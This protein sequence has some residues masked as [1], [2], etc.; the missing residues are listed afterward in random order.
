MSDSIKHECGLALIRLRKPLDYYHEKYGTALY[1][2]NKLHVLLQ[3]QRNRG[4]DG[5]GIA[6]IKLDPLPGN[7]Y[8]SRKRSNSSQYLKDLFTEVYSRFD[9]VPKEKFDDPQWLKANRPYTGEILLGH[10]RYG[11]H[12]A[13]TIETV[14]PFLRQNNWI[15]RN[16]VMAGNFNMTNMKELFDELISFGQH[17]KERS[18]TVTIMEKIGHFL[19]LEVDKLFNWF[20]AE[21]Y[22]NEE[23]TR[24]I[25]ENI[26]VK[27][28]LQ[29]ATRKIDGGYVM[30]GIIGH[31]DAFVMRDP[32][33][34]R[35]AFYYA[36]DEIVAVASERPALM[37]TFGVHY[38][39]IKELP[40]GN[41]LII[42]KSG[43]Y[44]VELCKDQLERKACSFERIYFSRGNDK[45][46]Y[47][48]RKE[49]GKLL[50]D[51]VLAAANYDFKH[52]VFSFIPNTAETAYIG[53]AEELQNICNR[54]KAEQLKA[55]SMSG[56]ITDEAIDKIMKQNPRMDKLAVKDA[57]MRTFIADDVSRK[58]MVSTVYDVTYGIIE[59]YKDTIV[60]MDDS[61]VRGTTLRD[62]VIRI[63]NRL[64]P[65]RIIVVSSAPQ[66]RYPDCYGIDMSKM[67]SFVAFN[68]LIALLDEDGKEH[69][70]EET[71]HRCVAANQRP[72][73]EI[74][75]EL[76]PL[77]D[78]YTQ[79]QISH[80]I[81]EML[82]P[83]D[84]DI[85]VTIIYQSIDDLHKACPDNTGDWY[86]SGNYPTLGG[87]RVVNK[88]FINYFEK[89]DVR[90]Y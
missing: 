28:V 31:G 42:K 45:E 53:M 36:D 23:I 65:K 7:R 22:T 8:I 58:E 77:Y 41:A 76:K 71:Y 19:D 27:R 78:I 14:H 89:S 30:A 67:N 73:E 81:S 26:D 43:D 54:M 61:I 34:I 17:P 10:L 6:T 88:A 66:I 90:A 29:R 63:L 21:G 11:T 69:L 24:L 68:A 1:G 37:T 80:K 56:N 83:K 51:K 85:D 57:K 59:N 70:V 55:A 16:L 9:D 62:S 75:N 74:T 32:A 64:K 87:N 82:T 47:Q 84:L 49:L 46:I 52:T 50:A 48:E 5:A 38:D 44:S 86:F 79:E 40:R 4:Q 35:P 20:K 3:K 18:D 33:G 72:L 60:V 12:G 39:D 15:T 2:L 25:A 13:N